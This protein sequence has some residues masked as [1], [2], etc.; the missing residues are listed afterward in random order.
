MWSCILFLQKVKKNISYNLTAYIEHHYLHKYMELFL[1]LINT[2][3]ASVG[4]SWESKNR[5]NAQTASRDQNNIV[6]QTGKVGSRVKK[7]RPRR[8]VQKYL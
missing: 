1:C 6:W 2:I 5:V 8:V 7:Y 3:I 4:R